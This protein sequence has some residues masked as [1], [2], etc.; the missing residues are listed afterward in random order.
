MHA[1][2][3]VVM[4]I[5]TISRILNRSRTRFFIAANLLQLV[6]FFQFRQGK[7]RPRRTDGWRKK[8]QQK[9]RQKETTVRRRFSAYSSNCATPEKGPSVLPLFEIVMRLSMVILIMTLTEEFLQEEYADLI[10]LWLSLSL[11]LLAMGLSWDDLMLA[12]SDMI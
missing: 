4:I 3:V 1:S 10:C 5:G 9:L 6:N 11:P 12:G 8:K 7:P 2:A